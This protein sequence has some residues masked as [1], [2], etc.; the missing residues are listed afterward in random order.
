M[1][2]INEK[3]DAQQILIDYKGIPE[4]EDQ[5]TAIDDNSLD[6]EGGQDQDEYQKQ[7][8]PFE[9]IIYDECVND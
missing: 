3:M 4:Q 9:T 8:D 1:S 5:L 7:Q 2:L 6:L